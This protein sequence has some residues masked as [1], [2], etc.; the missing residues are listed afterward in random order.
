MGRSTRAIGLNDCISYKLIPEQSAN[1]MIDE[2]HTID[3]IPIYVSFGNTELK[4][5]KM[6]CSS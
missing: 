2:R 1:A 6:V 5:G 4:Y 3:S